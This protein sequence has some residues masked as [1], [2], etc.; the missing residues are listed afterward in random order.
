MSRINYK[1]MILT[2]SQFLLY[3]LFIPALSSAADTLSVNQSLSG[4]QTLVSLNGNF[5]MGFFRPGNSSNFYIGIWFNKTIV[6][7][8]RVVWVANRD[9]PVSDSFTSILKIIDGNLVLLNE[10]NS[11]VWSTYMNSTA[12]AVSA[13]L[14]D[15][16]NLVLRYGSGSSLSIWQSFDHP[17]HTFMPGMKLLYN[18]RTNTS[19]VLTSWRNA[20]DPGM[21]LFSLELDHNNKQFLIKWNRSVEYWTS[22]SW[23]D[24]DKLFSLV[25][26]MRMNYIYN[27]S[28]VDNE[29]ESY[30]TYSLYNPS[31]ISRFIIDI[32]GQVKQ[33]SW[34]DST[35]EWNLFWPQPRDLCDVY[36]GCL[37]AF[38]PSSKNDWNLGS[39]SSGCVRKTEVNCS[40]TI[41]KP[42]FLLS[43]VNK[44]FLSAFLEN[45]AQQLDESACRCSCLHDCVCNAYTFISSKCQH[46]NRENLNKISL[47]FVSND[48]Y[49]EK[50]QFHIKVASKDLPYLTENS[51]KYNKDVNRGAVVGSIAVVVFV[52]CVILFMVRRRKTMILVGKTTMEGSLMA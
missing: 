39:F 28:Y 34:L 40:I 45:E 43:Y 24:Q 31:I 25:P 41:E 9:S 44:S 32:P 14:L 3:L 15:D 18:K 7:N 19:Q 52:L 37:I 46:W 21:G 5:E 13:T 23:N 38:K 16:G 51:C 27:F 17:T 2:A 29:N 12:T 48:S 47:G 11:L 33:L 6:T 42:T 35:R 49:L 8:E 1:S 30:F 36:G 50:S 26:E 10:S 20:E 22:G 4:N